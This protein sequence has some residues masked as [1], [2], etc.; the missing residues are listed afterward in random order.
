[1]HSDSQFTG[2]DIVVAAALV[3]HI[4][5]S[6][7][8]VTTLVWGNHVYEQMVLKSVATSQDI[9]FRY[10]VPNAEG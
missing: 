6:L 8:V 10:R 2:Q 7:T 9:H 4:L 3:V 5:F 1:M